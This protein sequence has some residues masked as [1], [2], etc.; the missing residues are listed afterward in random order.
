MDEK[1][2]YTPPGVSEDRAAEIRERALAAVGKP[3]GLGPDVDLAGFDEA[4]ERA[5]VDS[6]AS[7]E[8]Q[9][10]EAA[11]AVGVDPEQR[12]RSGSYVQVDRSAIYEAV[13]DAYQGQ[14]E[15]MS[16]SRA[17]ETYDGLAE[18]WWRL[19]D[20]GKDKYTAFCALH[21]A[22]GYFMR[23]KAGARI[24]HP[25]QSCLLTAENNVSQ[26]V[27]NIIIVE[28][29]AEASILT[30]CTLHPDVRAG[31]HIGIS[32]F[33]IEDGAS[34]T[35]T[36]IHNWA[37]SFHVRPRSAIR[38]GRDATFVNNYILLK[39]VASLQTFPVAFLADGARAAFNS[40]TYGLGDSYIDIGSDAIL[41]GEG[42][43]AEATARAVS[44]DRSV[45]YSRGR[46]TGRHDTAKAHLDCRGI[47]FSEDSVQYAIPEL[48]SD[49]APGAELSHEAAISPIAE[50]EIHYL[51]SRGLPRDEAVSMITRGFV[52]IEIP[53][54][55][56]ALRANIDSVIAA[57]AKE[58]M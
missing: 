58:A 22:E 9:V 14:V 10:R 27:H 26:N 32:E 29:G 41:E 51:M 28:E 42:S 7:L 25:I 23:V 44:A 40:I 21:E 54:L 12:E 8:K 45:I 17:L 3:A 11:F 35:F 49:G 37:E 31:I 15:V 13:Q 50:E 1:N 48:V 52:D 47:V 55:P 56:D 24:E 19:V 39:P 43:R 6:L 38:V 53:G 4:L 18:H 36:M 46:L 16:V 30:G 57:T 20:P 33:F 5:R 2:V 34:L